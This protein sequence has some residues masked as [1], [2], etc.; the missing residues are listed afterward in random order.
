MSF[1]FF[2]SD[3]NLDWWSEKLDA[4]KW[5][6]KPSFVVQVIKNLDREKMVLG[7]KLFL[8]ALIDSGKQDLLVF[9]DQDT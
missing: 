3:L 5:S 6:F 7:T 8:I 4:K 1:S 2:C 9:K